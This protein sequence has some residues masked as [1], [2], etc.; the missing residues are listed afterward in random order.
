VQGGHAGDSGA[1][2]VS[3]V[4]LNLG[5]GGV[6]WGERI[7]SASEVSRG[8][9]SPGASAAGILPRPPVLALDISSLP[10]PPR[11]PLPVLAG[12]AEILAS[13]PHQTLF[14]CMPSPGEEGLAESALAA[15]RGSHVAY[16]GEWG[17]GMTGTQALHARLLSS[18]WEMLSRMPVPNWPLIH[19]ELFLFTRSSQGSGAQHSQR[20]AQI[21]QSRLG[22]VAQGAKA[23]GRGGAQPASEQVLVRC[24]G[25][26]SQALRR[27]PRTRQLCLC[28]S[29]SCFSA[30]AGAH[31]ALLEL[32]FCG[33][34]GVTR[35][36]WAEWERCRWL[37]ED[38]ASKREWLALA[39]ATPHAEG[40]FGLNWS[41]P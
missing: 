26:G 34:A 40:G 3:R 37:G 25:C 38:T 39:R 2:G 1:G 18:E 32:N 4:P 22:R 8:M 31:A 11:Q 19:A 30:T 27:C 21:A 41:Q 13:L 36:P 20:V 23:G 10:P 15:F 29:S 33:L 16:V 9:S 17:T 5:A 6:S 12:T 24:A 28:S 14:L 7:S 35:P